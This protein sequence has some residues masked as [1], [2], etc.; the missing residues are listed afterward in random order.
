[1]CQHRPLTSRMEQNIEAEDEKD[2]ENEKCPE[3]SQRATLGLADVASS[4]SEL[5]LLCQKEAQR[6]RL[7]CARSA[8]TNGE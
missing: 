8:T 2:M 5:P 4:S 7:T 6:I 3:C 1:M